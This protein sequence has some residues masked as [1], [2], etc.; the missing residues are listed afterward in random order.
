MKIKLVTAKVWPK[1]GLKS[2]PFYGARNGPAK[3]NIYFLLMIPGGPIFGVTK[4][5]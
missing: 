4:R 5:I 1:G 2:G 3:I